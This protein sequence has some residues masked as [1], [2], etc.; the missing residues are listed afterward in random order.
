[1]GKE[2]LT[3]TPSP[4]ATFGGIMALSIGVSVGS[5]IDVGNH[6]VKV[7]AI[8]GPTLFLINVDGGEDITISD[9][10]RVKILEDVYVFAGVGGG[11]VGNRLAFEAPRSIPI[12]RKEG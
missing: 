12:H 3:S 10:E 11:G 9:K 8:L 7:K 2:S 5:K 1:M 6:R 4:L